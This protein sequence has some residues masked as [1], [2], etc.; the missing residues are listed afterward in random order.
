MLSIASGGPTGIYGYK[1]QR[2]R[3]H[4]VTPQSIFI[5]FGEIDSKQQLTDLSSILFF[6]TL[7]LFDVQTKF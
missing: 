4:I 7:W 1:M 6:P 5:E 2:W 3:S